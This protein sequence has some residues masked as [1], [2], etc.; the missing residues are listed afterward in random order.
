MANGWQLNGA[1]AT[2]TGPAGGGLLDVER[3]TRGLTDLRIKGASVTGSIFAVG[4]EADDDE[5]LRP[6]ALWQPADVYVRGCDLVA[7]YREPLGQPFNLQAYWRVVGGAETDDFTLDA[8]V[9][10]QTPLWEAYP[11]VTVS[12]ALSTRVVQSAD[13]WLAL[14]MSDNWIYAEVTCPGDFTLSAL[15]RAADGMLSSHWR[16]DKQFMEKGVIRRLRL[17]GA[18]SREND[19]TSLI[20]R[21]REE[22]VSAPPPLTT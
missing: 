16:F 5:M 20:S 22:L 21:L 7:T 4:I 1:R 10:V 12:S 18:F 15:E 2:L 3:P 9:S 8:I 14:R 13:E 11:C 17:R 6:D 19:F